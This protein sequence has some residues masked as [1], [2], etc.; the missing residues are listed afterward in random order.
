MFSFLELKAFSVYKWDSVFFSDW[1]YWYWIMKELLSGRWASS[2]FTH[3]V[4]FKK[5]RDEMKQNIDH[6][7]EWCVCSAE[8][9]KLFMWGDNTE[10]QIGLGKESHASSPQ[11]VSVGRPISW[12]SCGYYHSALVTGERRQTVVDVVLHTERRGDVSC[13]FPVCCQST[14]LCTRSGSATAVNWAS[15]PTSCPDT[16]SPSWWRPSRSPWCR[17]PAEGDTRWHSQ[18]ETR[19]YKYGWELHLTPNSSHVKAESV[20]MSWDYLKLS[21]NVSV[22]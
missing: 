11:E 9:G 22:C 14:E 5:L 13:V 1:W 10:G 20:L 18:V 21:F 8:S 12:V 6:Q 19:N 3:S 2:T 4:F 16:E 15:E 17:W 7:C